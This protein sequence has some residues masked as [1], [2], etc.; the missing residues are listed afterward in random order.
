MLLFFI[1]CY[2]LYL[3]VIYCHCVLYFYIE[4]FFIANPDNVIFNMLS[5]TIIKLYN[6]E[7]D[8]KYKNDYH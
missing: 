5:G 6:F 1:N 2:I 8:I 7:S 4:A 3:V